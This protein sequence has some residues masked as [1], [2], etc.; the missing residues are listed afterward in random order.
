MFP[1]LM[2]KL[3]EYGQ[4]CTEIP[5]PYGMSQTLDCLRQIC[6]TLEATADLENLLSHICP[7]LQEQLT[8]V[9]MQTTN[10]HLALTIRMRNSNQIQ[11][12]SYYG[13]GVYEM[14][15]ELG[16]RIT[17]LIQGAR[18]EAVLQ[19]YRSV[20]TAH[21]IGAPMEVFTSPFELGTHLRQ[22][23][24]DLVCVA[25][26]GQETAFQANLPAVQPDHFTMG[27]AG[28]ASNWRHLQRLS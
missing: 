23:N 21:H 1:K 17:I 2:S 20:L 7:A 26:Q 22:G 16:F 14:F 27:L 3:K 12:I 15:R 28:A 25:D 4:P 11:A 6:S 18:D 24:F 9:R 8:S 10:R 13:L 5:L 19:R